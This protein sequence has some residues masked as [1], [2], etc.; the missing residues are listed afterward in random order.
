[1]KLDKQ[2]LELLTERAELAVMI[3]GEIIVAPREHI[4]EHQKRATG[5][6]AAYNDEL[7]R[8]RKH[9]NEALEFYK[10]HLEK[11]KT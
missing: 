7:N 9:I 6:F 3:Y 2:G 8:M 4:D 10:K 1:M 5:A 11:E